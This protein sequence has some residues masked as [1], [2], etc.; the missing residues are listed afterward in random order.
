MKRLLLLFLSVI[1][2]FLSVKSEETLKIAKDGF[3][4]YRIN[5][6]GKGEGLKSY[7]GRIIAPMRLE[8]WHFYYCENTGLFILTT[9][10][11]N[12]EKK[13]VLSAN[14]VEVIP[15]GRYNSTTPIKMGNRIFIVVKNSDTEKGICDQNGIEIIPPIYY[16]IVYDK[17][18]DVFSVKRTANDSYKVYN[19]SYSSQPTAKSQSRSYP[20][21]SKRR[22]NYSDGSYAD[23]TENSDGSVTTVFYRPCSMCHSSG[24]CSLC[25]GRGGYWSGFGNYQNYNICSSCGG[26]GKCKY[27]Q[28]T[29]MS[30]FTSTY[31]PST[32]SSVGQDLWSGRTYTSDYPSDENS[33]SSGYGRRNDSVSQKDAQPCTKCGG[34][35]VDPMALSSHGSTTW[36]AY[37]HKSGSRCPYCGSVDSHWHDK[38]SRCNVPKY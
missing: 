31:Y 30:V 14:G 35:G 22:E 36:I 7:D 26:D 11:G 3:K 12:K 38:C 27:C 37:F 10:S 25:H 19:V 9:I 18:K 34:T 13:G 28:G 8:N 24:S 33:S 6:F 29:K 16:N 5:E 2:V 21:P 17:E 4:Y 15:P 32:Q 20:R 23:I 1:F